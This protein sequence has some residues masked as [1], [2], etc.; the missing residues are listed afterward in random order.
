MGTLITSLAIR[1][2]LPFLEVLSYMGSPVLPRILLLVDALQGRN[3][4]LKKKSVL[5]SIEAFPN[6]KVK[7]KVVLSLDSTRDSL[8][9][10]KL[11]RIYIH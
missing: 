10:L 1:R 4:R 9:T 5:K 3:I 8:T 7:S 11:R 6:F 2:F